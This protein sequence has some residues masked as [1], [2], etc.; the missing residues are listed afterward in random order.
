M[1]SATYALDSTWRP[2]LKD[3]G[4]SADRV[5]RRAGL[6]DEVLSRSALRLSASDFHRFWVGL[7]AECDDPSLPVQLCRVI[8]SEEFSPV[9]FA[10]VCSPNLL[11]ATQRVARFKALVAPIRMETQSDRHGLAVRLTWREDLPSPP[12]SLVATELLFMVAL[13]RMGT[14]ETVRPVRI[15]TAA[16][17]DPTMA[18]HCADY[19]G[20][21]IRTGRKHEVVFSTTDAQR[22]FLTA[23]EGIWAAFEPHLRLRLAELDAPEPLGARV[24][25]V[26]LEALPSGVSDIETTARRLT[27][28]PRT[29]QRQLAA[30]GITFRSILRETRL[31]LAEHYLRD[32]PIPPAEI[33]LLLG[34]EEAHSFHRAFR[35]WTGRTPEQVRRDTPAFPLP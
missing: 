21:S 1:L 22:P 13:A 12:D 24:R 27:M 25:A 35:G 16:A 20:V 34:F 6:P 8:R 4:V 10:A 9:L 3:L 26:L 11:I 19:L 29:L 17:C 32:T 14:R 18:A 5:L 2:L 31:A 30:E 33:A 15:T 28:S 23:N 7:E